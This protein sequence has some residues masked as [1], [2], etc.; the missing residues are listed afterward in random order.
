MQTF[1]DEFTKSSTSSYSSYKSQITP[2]STNV[3]RRAGGPPGIMTRMYQT[4]STNGGSGGFN[5]GQLGGGI[6]NLASIAGLGNFAGIPLRPNRGT[7][8]LVAVNETREKEKRELCQLNDKFAQYV[9]KVRF[10]EAQNRKLQLELEALQNKAGQGSSKIKEMYE[11]EMNEAKK[12]IDDTTRDRAAAEVKARDAEKEAGRYRKRYEEI[13]NSRETDRSAIDRLQQQIAEN[14][15][16]INLFRRRLADLEDEARRYK[17]E[18]QRLASEIARLQNEIQNETFVKSSLDTEKMALEDELAMLKQMH[19]ADLN[20]LRSKTVVD[21]NL[22]PSHFFRNELAQ[23]IRD[24]RNEFEALNDQQRSDL[25][26]RYMMSYNELIL[27]HQKPDLDP[28]QSEQQRIQEEKLRTTLLTTRNEVAHMKARNEELN[29]RIRELQLHIDQ[30]RDDGSRLIQKRASE[31][32]ELRRKLEQLK[33]EYEEVTNM[34]TSLEKEI[35]TYRELLEGTNNRE[36]LKQI[37][38]HVVEEARRMEA[39]RATGGGI[40]GSIG[41]SGGGRATTTISRTFITSSA[42]GGASSSGI[43][44]LVGSPG[45][46][47]AGFS[48]ATSGGSSYSQTATRRDFPPSS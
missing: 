32:D 11:V 40:A 47:S 41:Y 39:E 19:E 9:E 20:E 24:I 29:N 27:R 25:H 3:Q 18:T 15:A 26:N 38:D 21:V 31:I 33:K 14:E 6:S 36:G 1:E 16:Q 44:G 43:S 4:Y 45:R 22:D 5:A 28:I 17:A 35:N 12:L 37:V 2:R 8:A 23:A 34:K 13:L 10:L 48:G 7:S 30:E 46:S 42:S